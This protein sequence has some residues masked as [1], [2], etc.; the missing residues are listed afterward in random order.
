V[1][2]THLEEFGRQARSYW[3][4]GHAELVRTALHE[5]A[6]GLQVSTALM[7]ESFLL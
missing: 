2:L 4:E 1:V 5:A 6:P 3:D 7:G